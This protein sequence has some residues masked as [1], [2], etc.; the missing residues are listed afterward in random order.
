MSKT[1]NR[2]SFSFHCFRYQVL[3]DEK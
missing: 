2:T 1:V 3:C